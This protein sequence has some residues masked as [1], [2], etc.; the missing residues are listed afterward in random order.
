[1][2]IMKSIEADHFR[3]FWQQHFL[4]C[5]PISYL[6]KHRLTDRW[7]RFHS[8]PK[9]KRY[10]ENEAD[11]VEL[12]DR[13]NT[14]LLDVI[15]TGMCTLVL[16]NYSYAPCFEKQCSAISN[17]EFQEFLKLSKQDFD[18]D[19]LEIGE[20]SLYFNLFCTTH[21]LKSGSLDDIL[22]CVAEWKI[23]N[24]FV[25]NCDSERIFAPYDGGVD[26]ILKNAKERDE[27]KI[28]YKSWLSS[29]PQGL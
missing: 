1:M 7:F 22:L 17:F 16:G 12:L 4:N 15:G 23:T 25:I 13:Q 2:N 26:I 19:E 9:S 3:Y 24:F 8:L 27:F 5:P 29:H 18:P 6:F 28:K 10:A 20:E 14:V 11:I 21:S